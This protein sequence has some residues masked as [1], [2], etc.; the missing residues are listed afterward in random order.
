MSGLHSMRAAI[1]DLLLEGALWAD[2]EILIK[3]R[4][5]IWND[6]AVAAAASE[7]GQC[8]VIGIAK[9]VPDKNQREGSAQ[10]LMQVTIPV[11][12]IELPRTDPEED[13]TEDER[14]EATVMRLLG[15]PLGRNAL[16]YTL[17]FESFDE[18]ADEAYVIRQTI[19]KTKLLLKP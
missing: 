7:A 2:G 19:F 5:D 14:W 18:I 9:G 6:I 10:L 15:S 16:T 3:R 13:T 12:M 8:L 11:V 1:R 17:D 4:A